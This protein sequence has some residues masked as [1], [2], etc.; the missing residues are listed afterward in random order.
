VSRAVRRTLVVGCLAL[1]IALWPAAA[2]AHP[3][4]NFTVN[5]AS[6]LAISHQS[7]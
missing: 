4:G 1:A 3:L 5:T 6:R 7:I 2:F